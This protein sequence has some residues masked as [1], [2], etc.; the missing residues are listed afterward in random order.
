MRHEHSS[1][2]HAFRFWQQIVAYLNEYGDWC[3]VKE[4]RKG[5]NREGWD[6]D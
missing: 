2:F 5:V 6:P 3:G 1:G 4:V